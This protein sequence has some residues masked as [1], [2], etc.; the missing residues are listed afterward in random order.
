MTNQLDEGNGL[1]CLPEEPVGSWI[2]DWGAQ[3]IDA[4]LA[5]YNV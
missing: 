1:G 4:P 2:A 3:R 5:H